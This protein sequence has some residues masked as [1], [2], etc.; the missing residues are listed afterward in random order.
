MIDRV[1]AFIPM[2]LLALLAASTYWLNHVVEME[3]ASAPLRHDPD[4]IIK[5]FNI[6]RFDMTGALRYT[7]IADHME[8]YPDDDTSVVTTPHLINHR[9]P[10]TEIFARLALSGAQAK[11][12]DFV[13]NV[14]VVRRGMPDNPLETVMTTRMLTVFPDDETGY[15]T[16]PV[17]ITQGNSVVYGS[18]LDLNNK[19]GIAVLHGRVTGTLYS[20]RKSSP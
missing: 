20:H 18:S 3:G 16:T 9:Q 7:M 14:R 2:A 19:T 5:N 10:M 4:Y 6:R 1:T 8:H 17:T 15:A 13:D 12:I 11:Q